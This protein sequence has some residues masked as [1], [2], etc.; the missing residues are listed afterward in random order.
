MLKKCISLVLSLIMLSGIGSMGASALSLPWSEKEK[1][2]IDICD[3][4]NEAGGYFDLGCAESKGIREIQKYPD[5]SQKIKNVGPNAEYTL[6]FWPYNTLDEFASVFN[7]A[8]FAAETE[9][10]I[11]S[12]RQ[13]AVQGVMYTFG[14]SLTDAQEIVNGLFKKLNMSDHKKEELISEVVKGIGNDSNYV[15]KWS[16]IGAAVGLGAGA[17]SFVFPPIA[18]VAATAAAKTGIILG[19]TVIGGSAG[20]IFSSS[21]KANDLFEQARG[22]RI[23]VF[24]YISAIEHILACIKKDC[25]KDKNTVYIEFCFDPKDYYSL[26]NFRKLN[27][28]EST[29]YEKYSEK[30]E[31]LKSEL[32]EILNQYR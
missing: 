4:R 21:S 6:H 10:E 2:D 25:W 1:V 11:E 18:A 3:Q 12:T 22:R 31:S 20:S 7:R 32:P 14:I 30:F 23:D 27:V 9:K 29:N 26:V 8:L 15:K 16:F 13:K 24:N 17:L 19:G 28:P 5:K